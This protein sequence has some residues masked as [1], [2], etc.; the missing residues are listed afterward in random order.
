MRT[1]IESS[2]HEKP[3]ALPDGGE[4]PRV[5]EGVYHRSFLGKEASGVHETTAEAISN[6]DVIEERSDEIDECS[7][8]VDER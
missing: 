3:Q 4:C 6:E 5:P 7:D 2:D 1:A 8:E